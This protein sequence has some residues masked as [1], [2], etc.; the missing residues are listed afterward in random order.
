MLK[1][2]A[3]GHRCGNK[4]PHQ[5]T[6][7]QVWEQNS[8]P[9]QLVLRSSLSQNSSKVFSPQKHLHDCGPFSDL[10]LT[11]AGS[12][13]RHALT[14]ALCWRFSFI[15]LIGVQ[16]RAKKG[17]YHALSVTLLS[18]IISTSPSARE[19][20]QTSAMTVACWKVVKPCVYGFIT[21]SAHSDLMLWIQRLEPY[22]FWV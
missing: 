10:S 8:T 5:C 9:V 18:S 20:D 7:T 3:P 15:S 6:R 13:L 11:L 14:S 19:D 22:T 2:Q 12:W 17:S 21:L 4:I 16:F 1:Q